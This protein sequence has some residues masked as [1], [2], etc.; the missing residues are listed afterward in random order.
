MKLNKKI[1]KIAIPTLPAE[2]DCARRF[3]NSYRTLG[4]QFKR[5]PPPS[6]SSRPPLQ[7]KGRGH[8]ASDLRRLLEMYKR[9]QERIFPSLPFDEFIDRVEDLGRTKMVQLELQEMRTDMLQIVK[10][11]LS[12][13]V[14]AEARDTLGEEEDAPIQLEMEV[15][16][17][18]APDLELHGAGA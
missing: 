3:G 15:E 5:A 1:K 18:G 10:N 11:S 12:K 8:E 6:S 16:E 17:E 14:V 9:W 4:R 7:F 2:R 13:Q